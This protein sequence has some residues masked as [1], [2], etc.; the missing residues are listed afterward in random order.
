M[1]EDATEMKNQFHENLLLQISFKM[2]DHHDAS[3]FLV[4]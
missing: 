2:A 1:F 4:S 3:L